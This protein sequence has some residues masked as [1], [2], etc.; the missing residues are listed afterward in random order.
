[1]RL[2]IRL[3]D[4]KLQEVMI[5]NLLVDRTYALGKERAL[6]PSLDYVHRMTGILRADCGSVLRRFEN[7]HLIVNS[8]PAPEYRSRVW[9]DPR[10][11][12]CLP[13]P[14]QWR[15]VGPRVDRGYLAQLHRELDFLEN[16]SP[17]FSA[18]HGGDLVPVT[19]PGLK[20]EIATS[21]REDALQDERLRQKVA[22]E[23]RSRLA[24][25]ATDD[26][27]VYGN[28]V[29]VSDRK[30]HTHTEI[31]ITSEPTCMEKPYTSADI[32]RTRTRASE[33]VHVPTSVPQSMLHEHEHARG[34]AEE[35]DE[36][37]ALSTKELQER[38][39]SESTY[40]LEEFHKVVGPSARKFRRTWLLRLNDRW[41]GCALRALADVNAR[42]KAGD[43]PL[44]GWGETANDIFQ[45][46]KLGTRKTAKKG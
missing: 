28:S 17:H 37:R 43:R 26:R 30:N 46:N 32:G 29:H 36:L 27:D 33:H 9:Q 13:H 4:F 10:W 8:G 3:Y 38:L 35:D 1:M 6:I 23:L 45:R 39:D 22:D 14:D 41:A 7:E 5:L 40:L 34:L 24:P 44:V 11:Y 19:M 25:P 2:A 31:P 42:A 20:D 18:A 21:S 16:S 12:W 15:L